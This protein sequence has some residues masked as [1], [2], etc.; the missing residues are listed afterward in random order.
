MHLSDAMVR[1]SFARW[2]REAPKRITSFGLIALVAISNL[3]WLQRMNRQLA[4][5]IRLRGII[6]VSTHVMS[7]RCA[8]RDVQC[9]GAA[10]TP[11]DV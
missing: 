6:V 1:V 2:L 9:A 11:V 8:M 3:I 4:H 5:H 10:I 7:I